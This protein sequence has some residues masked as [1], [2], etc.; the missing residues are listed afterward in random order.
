MFS[1]H[2]RSPRGFHW[3]ESNS[4]NTSDP[5]DQQVIRVKASDLEKKRRRKTF[6]FCTIRGPSGK[7][8]RNPSEAVDL[9]QC[10]FNQWMLPCPS[11]YNFLESWDPEDSCGGDTPV[12]EKRR[13]DLLTRGE[14]CKIVHLRLMG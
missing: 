10:A 3:P 12:V 11:N 7:H 5:G 9:T 14:R 4:F 1:G 13:H 6:L 8:A 2:P